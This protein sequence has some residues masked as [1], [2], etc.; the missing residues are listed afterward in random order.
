MIQ[1]KSPGLEK[2]QA[3]AI[4]AFS[5]EEIN[6]SLEREQ[7]M[8]RKAIR[9]GADPAANHLAHGLLRSHPACLGGATHL[10]P[11]IEDGAGWRGRIAVLPMRIVGWCGHLPEEVES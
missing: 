7:Q 9:R 2:K 1:L 5:G 4:P 8:R 3:F 10:H 6:A 11:S